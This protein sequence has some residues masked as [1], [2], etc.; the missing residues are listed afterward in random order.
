MNKIFKIKFQVRGYELDAYGH[1]NNAVY[2]N[3]CEFARWCMME[4]AG[5]GVEYFK[6]NK[7]SPVIVRAEID[8]K[9]PC[10]LSEWVRVETQLD[11]V[12]SRVAVFNQKIIKEKGEVLAADCKMTMVTVG[13]DGKAVILPTDFNKKFST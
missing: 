9:Y 1:V 8:Y 3:Y 13:I 12:R 6:D 10:F 11:S 4:E 5:V 7:V 2:L